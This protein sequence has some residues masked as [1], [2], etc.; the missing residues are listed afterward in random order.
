[1]IFG[2]VDLTQYFRIKDIRKSLLPRID[3]TITPIPGM[4][5]VKF[6]KTNLGEGYI[7]VDIRIKELNK[8][9]LNELKRYLA[10]IL[11]TT[12]LKKLIL[13][14]ESGIYYMAKL[15]GVTEVDRVITWGDTTLTFLCPNPLG[16]GESKTFNLTKS[17][18]LRNLGTYETSGTITAEIVENVD[19]IEITLQNTG[20]FI[21]I[22][23]DFVAGDIVKINFEEEMIYKNGYSIMPD[24]YLESDFFKLPVGEFRIT[25]NVNATLEFTER[26][27]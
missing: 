15:D 5:G 21:Y 24:L 14:D 22:G 20:E 3:N 6:K 19:H 10:S 23:H 1:M 12:E 16:Y 9:R 11:F 2:N 18:T 4:P 27:L 26:W 25:S 17:T 13:P 8:E 7:Y